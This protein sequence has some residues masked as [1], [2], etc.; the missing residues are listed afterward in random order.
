MSSH[1]K[2]SGLL[3][4]IWTSDHT[5][6]F[7]NNSDLQRLQT[8]DRIR[9][10]K[11]ENME[12]PSKMEE[13][14]HGGE[15]GLALRTQACSRIRYRTSSGNTRSWLDNVL[16][17]FRDCNKIRDNLSWSSWRWEGVGN[18]RPWFRPGVA[19]IW[20]DEGVFQRGVISA[21][22]CSNTSRVRESPLKPWREPMHHQV[23]YLDSRVLCG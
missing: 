13:C 5:M 9:A 2:F 17:R 3:I 16:W 12:D 18:P 14:F 20:L 15:K 10:V 6:G 21:D 1:N 8:P 7:D 4:V 11:L 22:R 23:P 19:A